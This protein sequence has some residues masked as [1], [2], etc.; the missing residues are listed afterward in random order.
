MYY[1]LNQKCIRLHE[2]VFNIHIVCKI[3][4]GNKKVSTR[5]CKGCT[6]SFTTTSVTNLVKEQNDIFYIDK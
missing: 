2:A 3:I 1:I 5:K 6:I 4:S